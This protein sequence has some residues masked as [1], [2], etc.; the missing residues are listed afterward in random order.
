MIA[1]IVDS[2]KLF[3]AIWTS[4]A[5]AVGVTLAFSLL[6]VGA[7][8]SSEHGRSGRR[9]AAGVYGALATVALAACIAAIV[10]GLIVMTTK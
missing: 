9:V 7:A 10:L 5:G 8:R 3:Q 4:L 2:E 6:V 1:T